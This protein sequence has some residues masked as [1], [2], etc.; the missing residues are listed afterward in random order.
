MPLVRTMKC[1]AAGELTYSIESIQIIYSTVRMTFLFHR[2]HVILL[3]S[4]GFFPFWSIILIGFAFVFLTMAILG[5]IGYFLGCRRPSLE[6]LYADEFEQ[7]TP[8]DEYLLSGGGMT[9]RN[10]TKN[11][12]PPSSN[13]YFEYNLPEV[14]YESILPIERSRVGRSYEHVV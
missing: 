6:E 7:L 13:G 1:P 12:I 5:L 3:F 14:R 4:S 9:Q 10:D 11:S 2:S 8:D